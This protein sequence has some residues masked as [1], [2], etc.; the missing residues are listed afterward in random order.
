MLPIKKK[1]KRVIELQKTILKAFMYLGQEQ[2]EKHLKGLYIFQRNSVLEYY[3][4]ILKSVC[5]THTKM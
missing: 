4:N 2:N 5:I 3:V 1:I